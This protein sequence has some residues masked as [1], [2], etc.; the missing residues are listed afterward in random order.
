M[1]AIPTQPLKLLR[2]VP[3]CTDVTNAVPPGGGGA[4]AYLKSTG[5]YDAARA[6]S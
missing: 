5:T 6:F 4:A 2:S 1:I 3:V